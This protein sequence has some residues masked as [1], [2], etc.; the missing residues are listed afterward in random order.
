M[1]QQV[2]IMKYLHFSDQCT[3]SPDLGPVLCGSS[4]ARSIIIHTA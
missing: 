3:A 1:H 4:I 2:E